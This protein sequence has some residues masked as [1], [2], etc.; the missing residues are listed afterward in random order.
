MPSSFPTSLRTPGRP[1]P[2]RA[3]RAATGRPRAG[4]SRASRALARRVVAALLAAAAVLGVGR[5]AV[6]RPAAGSVPVVVASTQVSAGT[7]LSAAVVEIRHLPGDVIPE[8]AVR[9]LAAAVGRPAAS[10]LAPG[11]VLTGHDLGTTSL[12]DGQ[13][14]TTRA[15]FVPVPEPEALAALRAG[16]RVDLHSPVDGSVVAADVLVLSVPG[17][18]AGGWV[19]AVGGAA[20]AGGSVRGAAGGV[21]L[22]AEAATVVEVAAAGGA[23]PAGGALLVA[24]RP[25][26]R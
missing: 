13:A 5:L 3:V 2:Y 10:V 26:R 15:V 22:A 19:P 24:L 20:G 12:L 16:D 11:E 14:P 9:D 4:G 6:A 23:D 8:G 21:W 17:G 18:Q 1:E 7:P 25:G